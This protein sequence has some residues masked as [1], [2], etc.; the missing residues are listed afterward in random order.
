MVENSLKDI[1]DKYLDIK[2]CNKNNELKLII[3]L[4]FKIKNFFDNIKNKI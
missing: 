4:T 2:Y 3:L 1:S